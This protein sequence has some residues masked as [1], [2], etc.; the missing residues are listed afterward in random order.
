MA[1]WIMLQ[2][3]FNNKTV[4]VTLCYYTRPV[5]LK[6]ITFVENNIKKLNQIWKITQLCVPFSLCGGLNSIKDQSKHLNGMFKESTLYFILKYSNILLS[7][8]YM[9]GIFHHV[10]KDQYITKP[11]VC[12]LSFKPTCPKTNCF[13]KLNLVSG[14]NILDVCIWKQWSNSDWDQLNKD[15]GNCRKQVMIV[16]REWQFKIVETDVSNCTPF[17]KLKAK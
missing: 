5:S 10:V 13:Y 16:G 17:Q 6:N 15:R 4:L 3:N 7:Y 1:I 2:W 12:L 14:D 8:N 9:Q 11:L